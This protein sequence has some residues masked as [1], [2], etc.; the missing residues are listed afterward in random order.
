MARLQASVLS[1]AAL[2]AGLG[3]PLSA[4]EDDP[5]LLDRQPPF[6][7]SGVRT[8]VLPPGARLGGTKA[9][10]FASQKVTL[11]SWLTLGDLSPAATTGNVCWGYTSPSGREYAL[12]GVSS[13]TAF[14]EVTDPNDP[15]I[16]AFHNGPTSLWRDIKAWSHYV[17]AVS[18]GG[19]GIQVFDVQ[20][21]DAGS[22]TALGSVTTGGDTAT[23]TVAIDTASGYLYRSGGGNNGLRIYNLNASATNPPLVGTWSNKYVHEVTPVTY[24]SGPAAGKQIA[25]ACSGFNGGFDQTGLSIIDVTNKASPVVLKEIFWSGAQYSHQVWLSSDL[26]YAY[27]NDELDENGIKPTTTYVIDVQTPANAFLVGSFHNGNPAIGH[28][29]YTRPGLIF[30]ANYRSGLRVFD[31]AANPTNPPEVAWFD[32]YPDD[33]QPEFNGLWNNYPY[34]QSGIVLGSD[35]ERGL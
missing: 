14:V 19:S 12:M 31:T 24:T 13:G 3:L 21:I 25:Y 30:E 15:V 2:I 1:T 34:F 6:P 7:G 27:L 28:N 17:Y 29:L 20:N 18:E 9:A 16:V 32:T 4:H 8:G 26:K 33:D 23:H 35:L 5:K 11:L 10:G 22:V